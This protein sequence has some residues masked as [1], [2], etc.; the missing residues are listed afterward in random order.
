MTTVMFVHG[1]N[2]RGRR[3]TSAS[4]TSAT[5]SQD[6]G[7]TWILGDVVGGDDLGGI[8][9]GQGKSIPLFDQTKGPSSAA[10]ACFR[11]ASFKNRIVEDRVVWRGPRRAPHRERPPRPG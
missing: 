1:I 5:P 9:K 2:T 3:M 4:I 6:A 10:A 8:L 11:R 7:P